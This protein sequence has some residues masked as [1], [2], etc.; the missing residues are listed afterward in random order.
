LSRSSLTGTRWWRC[1]G[2][3]GSAVRPAKR[4]SPATAIMAPRR[5]ATARAGRCAMPNS[6]QL[7]STL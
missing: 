6:C 2:S 1:A 7:K 5:Y 3:L 4:S